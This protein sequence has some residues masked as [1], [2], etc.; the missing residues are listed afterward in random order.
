MSEVGLEYILRVTVFLLTADAD[1]VAAREAFSS[2]PC[3]NMRS[4]VQ[5]IVF[6]NSERVLNVP[7]RVYI[8]ELEKTVNLFN[9]FLMSQQVMLKLFT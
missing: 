9:I 4:G 3:A 1:A 2:Q 6:I 5:I 8:N 7:R